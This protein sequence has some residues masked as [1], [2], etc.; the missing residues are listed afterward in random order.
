[1]HRLI[2]ILF[3]IFITNTCIAA[4]F[5]VT[6]NADSG[7]GTLR[8]ALTLAAA[9]GSTEKDYINFNLP[10][11]SVG[12]RTINLLTQLPDISSNLVL[13][14]S[15]QPGNKFGVSDAKVCLAYKL[16]LDQDISGL[17]IV[18]QTDVEVYGMYVNNLTDVTG[19]LTI[20]SWNGIE[21]ASDKNIQIGAA[22]KGNVFFGFYNPLIVNKSDSP[23]IKFFE[24]LTIKANFFGIAPDGQT[25]SVNKTD[26]CALF[27]V[28]GQ[29]IIG[30]TAAE[31][32]VFTQGL[33]IYQGNVYDS[34]SPED[35]YISA[36]AT[37]IVNNNKVGVD[38]FVSQS[39]V[40]STGINIESITPNSKNTIYIEDNVITAQSVFGM[41]IY[42]SN[43]GRDVTIMRNYI[44]TDRARQK[45]FKT[46]GI[47]LNGDAGQI[48]IGSSSQADANYVTNCI[49]VWI[50]DYVYA[51]VNKNSFSC[52]PYQQPMHFGSSGFFTYPEVKL[53]KISNTSV[54]GTATPNSL[55]EL[56]YSDKCGTCL[57]ETYFA[58][59]TAD[60]KGNWSYNGLITGTVIA[61]ATLGK[62]T[63]NF[64]ISS[65]FLN[66]DDGEIV[67]RPANCNSTNGYIKNIKLYNL[68]PN[69]DTYT[70]SWKNNDNIEVGTKLDL[71]DVPAGTYTLEVKGTGCGSA[72]SKPITLESTEIVFN[73][74]NLKK[75]NAGCNKATGSIKGI[76][77]PEATKFEWRDANN[78][79][80]GKKADLEDVPAGS[81][82]LTASNDFGCSITTGPYQINENSPTHYP[83]YPFVKADA[84]YGQSNG[85]VSI[86]TDALV[87]SLLWKDSQEQP[88]WTGNKLTDRP[89]G[90]YS[91][92]LTDQN[93]C[94]SLYKSFTINEFAQLQVV[95]NTVQKTPDE[96]GLKT[97]SIQ[98]VQVSGGNPP[99][100]Y[101]WYK[102]DVP[103]ASTPSLTSVGAGD[104][105]LI[106]NDVTGCSPVT[107]SFTIN[108]QTNIVQ[109]PLAGNIQLCTPGDALISVNNPVAGNT[110]RLYATADSP[111]PIAEQTNGT[112]KVS[113]TGNTTY[114]ITQATGSCESLRTPVEA[115]LSLSA[116]NIANTFTPNGDGHN[117][118][119][120]IDGIENY[121]QAVV[122]IFNRNG[123]KLFESKG[124]T[125]PF[126]GSYNGK[127]LPYGSYFYIINLNK[128]C[129]L[130]SGSLTIIR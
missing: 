68:G 58:S 6:S 114:Y 91:L 61:S 88:L 127:P 116:I 39:F 35:Y 1:M 44:G 76:T 10:D 77:A 119:W 60:A 123:Q 97:G 46:G 42:I 86:T 115:V 125:Q 101:A 27:F 70:F 96:C 130:L 95:S 49:P 126:N 2:L 22:G 71:T 30:G 13:D 73:Y 103:V 36:P 128:N 8:E 85:S 107:A 79:I 117:D 93:D 15:T 87:K 43:I 124:Y 80:K 48:T 64:T 45:S 21:L 111:Q 41:A 112:F 129:N 109:P 122:Q 110:Y 89:P 20:K 118:Y 63:S 16:P 11:L 104:Y 53:T 23:G 78:Q 59:V 14:G 54:A 98:N 33:F 75:I 92:Y 29:V 28:I 19:A 94:E 66:I 32:N 90:T 62:S 106:V 102:Q 100:T 18:N 108:A 37:I 25:L 17:K 5:V 40:E 82:S 47:F 105:K 51:T 56:F 7:P 12:G 55:V 38:Y 84:C 57:P 121:P 99:Y 69:T 4:V 81:Y 67:R 9:N 72:F 26:Q 34:T 120:K 83:D 65:L 74:T 50:F 24:N 3:L 31:G 113:V 52:A